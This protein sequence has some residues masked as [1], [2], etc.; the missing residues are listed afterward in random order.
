LYKLASVRFTLNEHVCEHVCHVCVWYHRSVIITGTTAYWTHTSAPDVLTRRP[1]ECQ[2][3]AATYQEAAQRFH[4]VYEGDEI[5]GGRWMY[6]ERVG[7][8]Q[9][10]TWTKGTG[11]RP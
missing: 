1:A 3:K 4:V 6:S 11:L 10:D 5:K 2:E 9:P 7:G 8:Y